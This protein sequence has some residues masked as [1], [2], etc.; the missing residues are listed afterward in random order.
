V[1]IDELQD[2][3]TLPTDLSDALAQARGL[4]VGLTMAHQYREQ[5]PPDIRAGIDAN[6]R[7][8]IVF[9]LNAADAKASLR[10]LGASRAG[11]SL[12]ASRARNTPNTSRRCAYGCRYSANNPANV[13]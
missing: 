8:K 11:V 10:P 9:G 3:L 7:N 6:A 13:G 2:Y 4:G 1:Y 5:L 12:R